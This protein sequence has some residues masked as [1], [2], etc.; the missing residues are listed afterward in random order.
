MWKIWGFFGHKCDRFCHDIERGF[1]SL[2]PLPE[3]LTCPVIASAP[4]ADLMFDL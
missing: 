4:L 1:P 3:T 2:L